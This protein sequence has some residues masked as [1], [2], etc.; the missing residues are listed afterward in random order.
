MKGQEYHAL[1]Y[2]YRIYMERGNSDDS[3]NLFSLGKV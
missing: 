2:F 1:R 3:D